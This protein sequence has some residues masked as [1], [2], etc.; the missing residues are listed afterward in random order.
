MAYYPTLVSILYSSAINPGPGLRFPLDPEPWRW[1]MVAMATENIEGMS[2]PFGADVTIKGFK[3]VAEYFAEGLV[4]LKKAIEQ[5]DKDE[6]EYENQRDY[7]ICEACLHH[8]QSAANYSEFILARNKWL[9]NKNNTALRQA[10]VNILKRELDNSEAMLKIAKGD[11]R[12]GYEGSIGY[13][14]TP[15]EIVE[16][17]YDLKCS[18]EELTK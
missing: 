14:Y 18:I 17:I 9:E 5:S 3:K 6:W 10:V 1:G 8:L 2:Q 7:G 11:S 16:K 12:I 13:F 15:V 4:H